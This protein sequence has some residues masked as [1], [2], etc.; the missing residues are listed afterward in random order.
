M[1]NNPNNVKEGLSNAGEVFLERLTT[2]LAAT[3]TGNRSF[4]RM[5]TMIGPELAPLVGELGPYAAS[6]VISLLPDTM[7]GS[8]TTAALVKSGLVDLV[9]KLGDA[10]KNYGTTEEKTAAA[11]QAL[12]DAA[13]AAFGKLLTM[14]PYGYLHE[15]DCPELQ[16]IQMAMPR[17]QQRQQRG[18]PP[19][20]QAPSALPTVTLEKACERGLRAAPCCFNSVDTTLKKQAEKPKE[21]EKDRFAPRSPLAVLGAMTAEERLSFDTWL[22]ALPPAERLRVIKA[23]EELDSREEFLGMMSLPPDIR[24]ECL[25]L[26]E[27][28]NRLTDV[29]KALSKI[30]GFAC[31]GY[32]KAGNVWRS[33]VQWDHDN[34]SALADEAAEK[35]FASNSDRKVSL[36]PFRTKPGDMSFWSIFNPFK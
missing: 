34:F 31:R 30:W 4:Q 19:A 18:Q 8:S 9:T 2:K 25:T 17:P 36:N 16:R 22:G 24:A 11:T 33:L 1:S 20:P 35:F 6:M 3:T 32:D 7:L 12:P 27:N 13:N 23:L 15:A 28:R 29:K 26:L 21:K 10:V 14:D 5:M